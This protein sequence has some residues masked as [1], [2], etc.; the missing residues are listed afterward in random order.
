MN[1]V[2][3]IALMIFFMAGIAVES[4]AQPDSAVASIRM[5]FAV[6]DAPAFKLLHA[7]PDNLMRP[8]TTQ[9]LAVSLAEPI[10]NNKLPSGFAVELSPYLLI[11]GSSLTL[12]SYQESALQRILYHTRVS[13]AS[14]RSAATGDT[15][16]LAI[17]VRFTLLDESDLRLNSD[18]INAIYS[19]NDS[20]TQ[21]ISRIRDQY[22]GAG[23]EF[24]LK[25]QAE[26]DSIMRIVN[27]AIAV[28]TREL[29]NAI[30]SERERAKLD[31]WNKPIV[32]VGLALAGESA[33]SIGARGIVATKAALWF[34]GAG[35]LSSW[36][37]WVIGLNAAVR[38]NGLAE[39]SI[40]DGAF[41]TRVYAGENVHK[42]YLQ[43]ESQINDGN[44]EN[45]VQLGGETRMY[46]MLWLDFSVGIRKATME[47]A[48]FTS[49]VNV[50][51]GTPWR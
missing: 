41:S 13:V 4:A 50:R 11:G 21:L 35:N 7:Q 45:L 22:R 48:V 44:L 40:V 38:R 10:F 32:E 12:K 8:G 15:T 30:T 29:D 27:N 18:Y 46:E 25:P 28:A 26:Q 43:F 39:L 42:G 1:S 23:P 17:G 49:N 34:V 14:L 37:Q 2:R 5:N 33:D 3:G 24:Q 31:D 20:I 9:E 16:T 36:G 51:L 19:Y 6:P 47:Q